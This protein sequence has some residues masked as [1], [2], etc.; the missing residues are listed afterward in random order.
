MSIFDF[1]QEHY[2]LVLGIFLCIFF[3]L[4]EEL[5]AYLSGKFRIEPEEVLDMQNKGSIVH[6]IR[7]KTSYD[8]GHINGAKHSFMDI[9]QDKPE[10]MLDKKHKHILYC[11]RGSKSCELASTLRAKRGY[12]VYYLTGGL[13]LWKEEGFTTTKR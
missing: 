7:D 5:S 6:D 10:S 3:L 8:S 2:L 4:E 1:L 11:A 13:D 12:E 9:L